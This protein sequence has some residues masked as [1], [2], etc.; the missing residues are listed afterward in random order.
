[1]TSRGAST[2]LYYDRRRC[3]ADVDAQTVRAGMKIGGAEAAS[4]ATAPSR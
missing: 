4:F 2:A 1:M 3:L